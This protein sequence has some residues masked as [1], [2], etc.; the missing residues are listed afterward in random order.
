MG[1][2]AKVIILPFI[3]LSNVKSFFLATPP[4]RSPLGFNLAFLKDIIFKSSLLP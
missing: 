3:L 2:A 4:G 1:F